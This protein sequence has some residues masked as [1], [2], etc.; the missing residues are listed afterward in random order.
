MEHQV[1]PLVGAEAVD[2]QRAVGVHRG[3]RRHRTD[4]LPEDDRLG[5]VDQVLA[6]PRQ[7]VLD[8]DPELRA[9]R[10]PRRFRQHQQP[11]RVD[12]ARADDD[13]A[14]AADHPGVGA[15]RDRPSALEVDRRTHVSSMIVRFSRLPMIECR[16]ETL[17]EERTPVSGS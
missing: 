13:L 8:L 11:R 2:E 10:R 16:Y 15:H 17:D 5:M 7:V 3:P 12:R 1:G 9:G 6:D 14:L 4:D